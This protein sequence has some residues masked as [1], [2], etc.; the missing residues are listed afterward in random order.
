MEYIVSNELETLES[1]QAI[2]RGNLVVELEEWDQ[3][4]M[5][6]CGFTYG[7]NIY[8]NGKKIEDEDG[9]TVHQALS[10]VLNHLGYNVEVK[11]R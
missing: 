3:I 1:A 2:V 10:A 6:G 7:T 11:N 4:G 5:N 8:V 9:T